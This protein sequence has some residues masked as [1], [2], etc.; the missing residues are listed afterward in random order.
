[1]VANALSRRAGSLGSLAYLSAAERPLALD[2]QTLANQERQYDD[3][4]LLVFKDAVQHGIFFITFA[5]GSRVRV[6]HLGRATGFFLRVREGLAAA[7]PAITPLD[8][9][10]K[11]TITEYDEH[12][13]RTKPT[14]LLDE[15]LSHLTPYQ[16]LIGKLLY[17]T[18]TRPNISFSVQ[19]PSQFLQK[20]KKSHIESALRIVK[21]IKNSRGQGILLSSTCNNTIAAYYDAYWAAFPHSRKSVSGYL[22]KFG[23]ILIS[24]RS[25]KQTTV[26]RS[27]AEVSIEAL[28][29]LW[30]NLSG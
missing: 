3:P 24:W 13:R 16:K 25:K 18:M 7:K 6:R 1:M 23:D 5:K 12:L 19:T 4:H 11:L 22:I 26:S 20:S 29:R 28:Q 15:E 8:A 17:L 2:V 27:S 21:Y 30:Q 14:A 9:N 10:M